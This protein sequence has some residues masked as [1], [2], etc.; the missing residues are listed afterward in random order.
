MINSEIILYKTDGEW[1]NIWNF[2][3]IELYQFPKGRKDIGN[4]IYRDDI[5]S[6]VGFNLFKDNQNYWGVD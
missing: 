5:A 4:L 2:S 1:S 6:Q 3:D